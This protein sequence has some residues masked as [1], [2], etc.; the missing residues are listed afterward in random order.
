MGRLPDEVVVSPR[1]RV[2]GRE[3]ELS[4][5]RSGGPGGQHVNKTATKVVLRWDVRSSEALTDA[6]RDRVLQRLASRIDGEGV[7]RVTSETHRDQRRNVDDAL[8]RF[9]RL[10][11]GALHKPKRRKKTRPTK[12][13]QQR[14]LEEKRRRGVRKRQ[15]RAPP[16]D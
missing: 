9:A 10:L 14:R 16:E 11:R 7:L 8:D 6:E 15:R 3:L 4:Y 2:P 5:A 13:S 1:V 12:A